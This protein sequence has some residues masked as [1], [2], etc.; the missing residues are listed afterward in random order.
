MYQRMS[1]F[2]FEC[3]GFIELLSVR[4]RSRASP[5]L[6]VERVWLQTALCRALSFS[7]CA[8]VVS[9]IHNFY[10]GIIQIAHTHTGS[11]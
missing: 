7:D 8:H 6:G 9:S 3:I 1:D 10:L 11:L 4:L 5:G 2:H